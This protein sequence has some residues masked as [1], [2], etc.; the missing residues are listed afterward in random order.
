[1]KKEPRAY[2]QSTRRV[3]A[4][5]TRVLVLQAARDLLLGGSDAAGFTVDA[6]ARQAGVARATVFNGFGGKH[7][8][9]QALFDEMSDRAGLM[10]VD[11]LL[12]QPDA[13]QALADYVHAFGA[14]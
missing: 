9:L 10:D 13:G 8:L 12:G 6:V 4:G 3:Q 11:A 1:M 5:L 14:F 7:G 2:R